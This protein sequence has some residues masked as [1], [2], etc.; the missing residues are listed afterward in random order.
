MINVYSNSNADDLIRLYQDQP[1]GQ[2]SAVVKNKFTELSLDDR[3]RLVQ[4]LDQA[5]P[6]FSPL[7]K[8]ACHLLFKTPVSTANQ[9]WCSTEELLNHIEAKAKYYLENPNKTP[10]EFQNPF[11]FLG[12][13]TPMKSRP[14]QEIEV[15][16]RE[17]LKLVETERKSLE[18]RSPEER[19]AHRLPHYY[20]MTPEGGTLQLIANEGIH[21]SKEKARKGA[22][23]SSRIETQFGKW[24]VALTADILFQE[25]TPNHN[26]I[27]MKKTAE[28][29]GFSHPIK[30]NEKNVAYYI[31]P[32][33][34]LFHSQ[35]NIQIAAEQLAKKTG[36]PVVPCEVAM[37]VQA[38]IQEKMGVSYPVEW[39]EQES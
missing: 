26:I 17:T 19:I 15:I 25:K 35:A 23:V 13:T 7:R 34:Q 36:K 18:N 37:F 32:E 16:L 3:S 4:F 6:K 33:G 12:N 5:D 39:P 24:G 1:D 28:W 29:I 27:R 8:E 31:L 14:Q 38:A 20:H 22:F 30:L 2:V 11:F 9:E 21:V 10:K